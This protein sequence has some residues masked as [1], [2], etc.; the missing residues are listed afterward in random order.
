MDLER[1]D[2]GVYELLDASDTILYIGYGK[3]RSSLVRHFED[4]SDPINGAFNF[5]V[6]YLWDEEKSRRRQQEE[7]EKYLKKHHGHPKFNR[8]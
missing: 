4:G 7:L 5:S 6:E 8:V 1:D 3:V 2:Y